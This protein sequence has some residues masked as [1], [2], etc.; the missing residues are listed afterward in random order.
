MT[1]IIEKTKKIMSLTNAVVCMNCNRMMTVFD[2][3]KGACPSCNSTA[4]YPANQRFVYTKDGSLQDLRR[5]G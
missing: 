1:T 2:S 5:V 3:D 4:L